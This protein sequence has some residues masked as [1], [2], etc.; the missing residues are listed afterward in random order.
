MK[1]SYI[2]ILIFLIYINIF[3]QNNKYFYTKEFGII[4]ENDAYMLLGDDGYYTNGLEFYV[5]WKSKKNKDSL[6]IATFSLGQN[7]YNAQNGN[8]SKLINIDR[9]VTAY[10]YI[11]Y[12]Q[13][14]FTKN[15]EM[16]KWGV[17]IASIGPISFGKETQVFI[18]HLFDMYDPKKQWDFQ[19]KNSIGI[20][21]ELTWIKEIPIKD[22]FEI[23][24]IAGARAGL[25]FDNIKLGSLIRWGKFNNNLSTSYWNTRLNAKDKNSHKEFFFY[26][27]PSLLVYA[28]NATIEGG[29]FRKDKGPVTGKLN[30]LLYHQIVGI[31]KTWNRYALN[32]A[33]NY[34]TKETSLQ[35]KT[36]WYGTIELKYLF[37]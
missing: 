27:Q 4:S 8:Y 22:N 6:K 21:G 14:Q 15:K 18:H 1:K 33:I 17:S 10:L 3:S 7:I 36:Q 24:A 28:Y 32:L 31:M 35:E 13:T 9:P 11:S 37:K 23:Q 29:A 5:N 26:Y 19:L 30:P 16:I 12:K 20:N 34:Q 2:S 25:F